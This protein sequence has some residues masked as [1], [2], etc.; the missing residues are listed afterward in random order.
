MRLWI[1]AFARMT[2]GM[3]VSHGLRVQDCVPAPADAERAPV[4]FIPDAFET[5]LKCGLADQGQSP[6]RR[7]ALE[8]RR[9]D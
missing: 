1:L 4:T 3:C 8:R 7:T 9:P 5:Q 6:C 2:G